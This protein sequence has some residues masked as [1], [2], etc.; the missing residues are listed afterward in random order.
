[1]TLD[2]FRF[3]INL[4]CGF[5]S[6]FSCSLLFQ[7]YVKD[8]KQEVS[9]LKEHV[10]SNEMSSNF[11]FDKIENLLEKLS[12]SME[13]SAKFVENKFTSLE[14]NQ[15]ALDFNLKYISGQLKAMTIGCR[16]SG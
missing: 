11:R 16:R 8:V 3:L 14:K 10:R 6:F 7:S 1:M 4:L 15:L 2:K 9:N 12:I 5:P 13:S